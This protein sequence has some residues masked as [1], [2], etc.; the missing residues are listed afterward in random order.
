MSLQKTC[1]KEGFEGD[2]PESLVERPFA[3]ENAAS[4]AQIT[5]IVGPYKYNFQFYVSPNLVFPKVAFKA[6]ASLA[7][8]LSSYLS[9]H[10]PDSLAQVDRSRFTVDTATFH[11]FTE[12]VQ[13]KKAS[14]LKAVSYFLLSQNFKYAIDLRSAQTFYDRLKACAQRFAVAEFEVPPQIRASVA[15]VRSQFVVADCSVKGQYR[16][17]I[18]SGTGRVAPADGSQ[19]KLADLGAVDR[20]VKGQL[21]R[22]GLDILA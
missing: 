7:D 4:L 10:H 2:V 3:P 18:H 15:L 16:L 5:S 21:N 6:D 17:L 8:F 9:T 11:S 20:A 14:D 22:R 13:V 12:F 19:L 1:S